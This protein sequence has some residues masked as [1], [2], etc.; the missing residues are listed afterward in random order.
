MYKIGFWE[1]DITPALGAGIPGY[2]EL[3]FGTGIKDKLYAKAVAVES[4]GECVVMV[5][6]DSCLYN[7]NIYD[8]IRDRIIAKTG[9]NSKN[10][11]ILSLKKLGDVL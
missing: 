5:S 2:G 4:N 9:L 7:K 6:I 11:M 3:R 8:A 1:S 10:I